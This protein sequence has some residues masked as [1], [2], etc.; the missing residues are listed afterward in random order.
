MKI[1]VALLVVLGTAQA[2]S[3]EEIQGRYN[4]GGKKVTFNYETRADGV[5]L[6][7]GD[8]ETLIMDGQKHEIAEGMV[9]QV[10]CT[11]GVLQ[12]DVDNSG[13]VVIQKF[14]YRDRRTVDAEITMDGGVRNLVCRK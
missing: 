6:L 13:L 7:T 5:K 9:Y 3:C 10:H 2:W 11:P 12:I 1:L 8:G 14:M 4:C